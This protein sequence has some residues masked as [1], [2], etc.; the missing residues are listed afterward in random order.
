[1]V[2]GICTGYCHALFHCWYIISDLWNHVMCLPMTL[3][4]Y[5]I[6]ICERV[7]L[8]QCQCCNPEWCRWNAMITTR[9]KHVVCV[10]LGMHCV[11]LYYGIS[12]SIFPTLY[13]CLVL[14]L[15]ICYKDLA[16]IY[17]LL[18][19][20]YN[21]CFPG[22]VMGICLNDMYENSTKRTGCIYALLGTYFFETI[23]YI[24]PQTKHWGQYKSTY[25]GGTSPYC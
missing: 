24:I 20:I 21:G 7:W 22:T 14:F 12:A 6:L 13:I 17:Y 10:I 23:I 19:Y 4:V 1:M 15:W 3:K 2:Y 16:D 5:T 8:L 18:T 11:R 9:H 25:R